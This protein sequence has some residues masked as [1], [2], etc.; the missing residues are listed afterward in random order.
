VA[1]AEVYIDES[2][3]DEAPPILCLAG[4]VFRK[5]KA[6][7]FSRKWAAYL[8]RKGLPYFHMSE[9]A[10]IEE[11]IFKGNPEL[12]DQVERE[13]I[14]RTREATEI[15]LA[16]TINED[17]YA[18]LIA[19]REGMRSAYAAA[20]LML[21]AQ[22]RKWADRTHFNGDIAYFFEAGH[23]HQKDA[24]SFMTWMFE[25]PRVAAKFRYA[26]HTFLAKPTPALHPADL[27][28]WQWRLEAKRALDPNR[29]H[30]PR[31]D[32]QALVRPHDLHID[33]TRDDVAIVGAGMLEREYRREAQIALALQTGVLPEGFGE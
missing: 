22:V 19:P 28:A 11:G 6:K 23:K 17:D 3:D 8:E 13:L 24:N 1:L 18:E 31:R 25:S 9:A 14:R 26:G 20:L 5:H 15:G 2:Y 10:H 33:W 7:E 12:A 16:M 27:L 32:L 4:Y 29:K 30:P 21:M